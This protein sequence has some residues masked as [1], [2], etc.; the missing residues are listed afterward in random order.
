MSTWTSERIGWRGWVL[1]A[2]LPLAGC[3]EIPGKPQPA[4]RSAA[5]AGGVL[6]LQAPRGYCIDPD[7]LRRSSARVAVLASCERLSGE[8]GI[9]VEPAMM[10]VSVL[11][12]GSDTQ[13]PSPESLMRALAPARTGQSGMAEGMAYVQ[14]LEG[15]AMGLPGGDAR[16]WRGA[17]VV[18]GHLVGLALYAPEGSGLTGT[19]GLGLLREVARGLGAGPGKPV[20]RRGGSFAGLFPVSN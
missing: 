1:A 15:G 20:A 17:R 10:T 14:V 5:V 13:A 6:T 18:A 4:I 12:Q 16:H 8:P 7:S 11:P 19:E 9:A 2:L 3:L